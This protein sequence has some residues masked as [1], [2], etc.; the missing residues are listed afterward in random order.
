MWRVT[1]MSPASS[2]GDLLMLSPARSQ[3]D[4]IP[5]DTLMT[6]TA[7]ARLLGIGYGAVV[8]MER[9]DRLPDPIMLLSKVDGHG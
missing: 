3:A 7:V 5:E 9:I 8:E 1:G 6:R 4:V 2:K